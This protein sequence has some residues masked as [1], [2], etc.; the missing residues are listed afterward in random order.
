M[1]RE[2]KHRRGSLR[3]VLR[4]R[5]GRTRR[6]GFGEEV[7]SS[8]GGFRDSAGSVEGENGL[9]LGLR[10]FAEG[11]GAAGSGFSEELELGVFGGCLP[12]A[13]RAD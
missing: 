7:D 9:Q 4:G 8:V 10:S 13:V 11:L 2:S 3:E 12:A 1:S 5:W 6:V